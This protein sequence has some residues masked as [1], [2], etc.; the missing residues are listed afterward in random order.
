MELILLF[1][2]AFRD[3][4]FPELNNNNNNKSEVVLQSNVGLAAL[5]WLALNIKWLG[6][7]AA[8][9]VALWE[10]PRLVISG[11]EEYRS[12]QRRITEVEEQ[13]QFLSHKINGHL[14]FHS[15]NE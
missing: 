5:N 3:E 9:A 13:L 14:G 6:G 15:N 2:F 10:G 11:I 12:V 7:L 1:F 8:G 4:S